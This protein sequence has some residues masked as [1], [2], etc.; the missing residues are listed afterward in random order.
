[1]LAQWEY[2]WTA[3]DWIPGPPP[4]SSSGNAVAVL[5]PFGAGSGGNRADSD[6][7]E[8]RERYIRRLMHVVQEPVHA[9]EPSHPPSAQPYRSPLPLQPMGPA[10][11]PAFSFDALVR[12]QS[13]AVAQARAAHSRAELQR[14]GIKILET[15]RALSTLRQ[16]TELEYL[17]LLLATML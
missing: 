11:P 16:Q 4:P 6:F 3:A 13:L 2:F 14:A 7:W 17:A 1:M 8:I 12:A 9:P 5:T 15:S 10:T